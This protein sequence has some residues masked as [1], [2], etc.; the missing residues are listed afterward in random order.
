MMNN[1]Q[2]SPI[3]RL[4]VVEDDAGMVEMMQH[5]LSL[6]RCEVL[7]ARSG[8]EALAILHR[9]S[10]AGHEVNLILLDIMVPGM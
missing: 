8:E 2:R 9:E 10:A 6:V 3:P 7:I 4:L 1:I 5:M